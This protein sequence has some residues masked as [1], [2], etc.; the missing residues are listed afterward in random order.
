[1]TFLNKQVLK[2]IFS[3]LSTSPH[4]AAQS[5]LFLNGLFFGKLLTVV[6]WRLRTVGED[7]FGMVSSPLCVEVNKVLGKLEKGGVHL[8]WGHEEEI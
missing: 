8:I 6:H 1:M 4:L 3:P 2:V 5:L 7:P